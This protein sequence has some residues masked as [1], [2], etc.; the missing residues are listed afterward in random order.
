MRE[1]ATATSR[2]AVE[3]SRNGDSRDDDVVVST[4]PTSSCALTAFVR[5]GLRGGHGDERRHRVRTKRG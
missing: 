5:A 1:T 3:H 4:A 2:V